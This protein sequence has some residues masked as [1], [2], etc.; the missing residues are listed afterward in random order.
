MDLENLKV[1]DRFYYQKTLA[2]AGIN[3]NDNLNIVENDSY[4]E[5]EIYEQV[6]YKEFSIKETIYEKEDLYTDL[7]FDEFADPGFQYIFKPTSW[8]SITSTWKIR[9]DSL[10]IS[11]PNSRSSGGPFSI[12]RD[13]ENIIKLPLKDQRNEEIDINGWGP[14]NIYSLDQHETKM[15]YT[16]NYKPRY[17]VYDTLNVYSNYIPFGDGKGYK[18]IIYSR[19]E[20]IIKTCYSNDKIRCYHRMYDPYNVVQ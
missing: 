9:R 3:P 2:P 18:T 15:G 19:E 8:G 5:L 14:Q 10:I 17:K 13:F 20:G 7:D 12:F 11:P 4:L 16:V 1:G 6:A